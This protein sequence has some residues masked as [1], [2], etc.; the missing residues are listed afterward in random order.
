MAVYRQVH[1]SYWQDAFVLELTPEEKYFYLYLMTNSKTRQC[2]IYELPIKIIELETGYNTETIE[3]LIQKFTE[4]KKIIYSRETNE[5]C[6]LNWP[7]YNPTKNPKIKKCVETE[8]KDIKNRQLIAY[9]Y[10]IQVLS[11]E[12]EEEEQ[13]EEKE[14]EEYTMSSTETDL[15]DVDTF[16]K[17]QEEEKGRIPYKT[18]IDYLNSKA[19]TDYCHTTTATKNKIKAR[20][21]E[22][23]RLKDFKIV[24]DTKVRSWLTDE[25]MVMYLRPDT[26]FSAS[27][28]EGYLQEG[29][30]F[31][32]KEKC[33]HCGLTDGY[34]SE[35]CRLYVKKKDEIIYV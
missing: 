9:I 13:E 12:E 26:L 22:G 33:K 7:K 34:H 8:L 35:S 4:Y 27:K 6:I 28:F 31:K 16:I 24:I 29:L 19:K 1:T 23:F 2:G 17:N 3:K 5:I 10:P 32:P 25:K 21:N 30:K 15:D 18:I 14:K 20:W 11:Q